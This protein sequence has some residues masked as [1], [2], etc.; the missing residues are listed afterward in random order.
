MRRETSEEITVKH[1]HTKCDVDFCGIEV[2]DKIMNQCS[3]CGKDLCWKHCETFYVGCSD[4]GSHWGCPDHKE[5]IRKAYE[6]YD[7]SVDAL[8]DVDRI[9]KGM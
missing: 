4:H 5:K 1:F 6:Q 2:K 8:P 7:K 3:I 9:L